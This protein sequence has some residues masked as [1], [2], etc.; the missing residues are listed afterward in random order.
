MDR[1]EKVLISDIQTTEI[2]YYDSSF[3]EKCLNF[4]SRRNIDYLP[5]L[6]STKEIYSLRKQEKKFIREKAD[7]KR[8]I[9][10]TENIFSPKLLNDFRTYHLLLVSPSGMGETPRL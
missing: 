1:I 5:A 3:K 9:S 4:C 7:P 10:A 6:N 8:I 2:L